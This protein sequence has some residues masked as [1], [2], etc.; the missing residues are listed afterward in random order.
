MAKR[1][2]KGFA[3]KTAK[4]LRDTKKHCPVC[5][6]AVTPVK[7]ITTVS[8]PKTHSMRFKETMVPVCKCNQENYY[9]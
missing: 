2:T 7:H 3:D 9:K 6:E 1:V 5:G 8:D 4:A